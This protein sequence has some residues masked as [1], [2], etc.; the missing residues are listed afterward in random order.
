SFIATVG[1]CTIRL[2]T[3]VS[4]TPFQ[5]LTMVYL[6]PDLLSS[7]WPQYFNFGPAVGA[8]VIPALN[9]DGTYRLVLETPAAPRFITGEFWTLP[10]S[11]PAQHTIQASHGGFFQPA[12]A[13]FSG[14]PGE[15]AM[16]IDF[17]PFPVSSTL[18]LFHPDGTFKTLSS[19]PNLWYLGSQ[20][21][22]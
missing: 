17:N 18:E 14:Q 13:D 10:L 21:V 11:A 7:N 12:V 2:T 22:V 1:F 6:E 19:N 4:N 5:A 16:M 3:N 8:G 20:L 9:P 15:E